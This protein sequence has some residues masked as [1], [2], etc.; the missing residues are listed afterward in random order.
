[1][2]LGATTRCACA[3]LLLSAAY[4]AACSSEGSNHD[5]SPTGTFAPK[6]AQ[7]GQLELTVLDV[8]DPYG[9]PSGDA[10]TVVIK[11]LIKNISTSLGPVSPGTFSLWDDAGTGYSDSPPA[12]GV[13]YHSFPQLA[14]GDTFNQSYTFEL[15]ASRNAVMLRWQPLEQGA[16]P[17]DILLQ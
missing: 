6:V 5:T 4:L 3:V 11:V 13:E 17:V 16:A 10:K 12:L 7:S 9:S 8:Q 15:P 14:V 1:M 2:S